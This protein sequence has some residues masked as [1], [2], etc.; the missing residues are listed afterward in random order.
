VLQAIS[1][2]G[3]DKR[4]VSSEAE[5]AER[6]PKLVIQYSTNGNPVN[7]APTVALTAPLD[8]ATIPFG[9]SVI[10]NATAGDTDGTVTKVEFYA[11]AT[12]LGEDAS[13]PY[14]YT[15]S[16]PTSGFWSLTAIAVDDD[17]ASTTSATVSINVEGAAVN[18]APSAI[19]TSPSDGASYFQGDDITL[20]SNAS[21]SDGTVVTVEFYAGATKLGEDT[22]APYSFTWVNPDTGSYALSARALDDDGASGIS[23]TATVSVNVNPSNVAPEVSLDSPLD[24]TSFA[25]N[26]SIEL[27]ATASDADGTVISVAF[28]R[29]ATLVYEDTSAPFAFTWSNPGAGSYIVTAVATDNIGVSTVSA[30]ANVTV[31][32]DPS[33]QT[34]VLQEGLNGY[35][36]TSD[37][38]AYEYHGGANFG[39]RSYLSEKRTGVRNRS[40]VQFAIFASEGGPVPDGATITSAT[41]S[42]YKSSVYDQVYR[43]HPLLSEWKE[44]EVSWNNRKAGVPWNSPGGTGLGSDIATQHDSDAV[45]LWGS[46]W[47]DF[48]VANRLQTMS[49]GGDNF[50]WVLQAISGNGNDKRY[51]SSEAENAERRP[52]LVVHYSAN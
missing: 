26:D 11:G 34:V 17:N 10:F 31:E 18:V 52:K 49:A 6:R 3:N 42:L 41:L 16:N 24:G 32:L 22:S 23:G 28:Y 15:W 47:V 37:S 7:T 50:G 8:G 44:S 39:S 36:G 13:A 27:A 4:Y 33:E 21:D 43:L 1:G 2:N 12:K 51:V 20:T 30:I 19:L 40:F 14:S 5:N 45:A 35:A 25:F 38:Y 46:M 29:G 48:E 9:D